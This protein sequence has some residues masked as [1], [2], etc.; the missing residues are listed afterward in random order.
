MVAV[1]CSGMQTGRASAC[2]PWACARE[3]EFCIASTQMAI[4]ETTRQCTDFAPLTWT[5]PPVTPGPLAKTFQWREVVGRVLWAYTL[6]LLLLLGCPLL[7][8]LCRGCRLPLQQ[9]LVHPPFLTAGN[10]PH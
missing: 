9:F 7:P 5:A 1:V 2:L 10:P 4:F 3:I 6:P 8:L